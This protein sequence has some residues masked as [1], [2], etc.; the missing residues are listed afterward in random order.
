MKGAGPRSVYL[1]IY[2]SYPQNRI[3]LYSRSLRVRF[4]TMFGLLYFMSKTLNL[5][6][7]KRNA[8]QKSHN[9]SIPH[10]FYEKEDGGSE[11]P[12]IPCKSKC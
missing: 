2:P 3:T 11:T 12:V 1:E 4:E 8:G 6:V 9:N 5:S 7:F 10:V